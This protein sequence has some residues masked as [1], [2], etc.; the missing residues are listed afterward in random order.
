MSY[1]MEGS[2][3]ILSSPSG[4]SKTTES[5]NCRN[6]NFTVSVSHTENLSKRKME[7]ITIL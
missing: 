6:K 3:I 4:A 2:M 7:L 5:E 1:L